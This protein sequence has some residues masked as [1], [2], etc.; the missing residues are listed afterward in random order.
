MK[1]SMLLSRCLV[2]TFLLTLSIST[3]SF[4]Q[5]STDSTASQPWK[6]IPIPPLPAFHPEQPKRIVLKNGL[7]IFLEEDHELPFIDGFIEM[8]GGGRDLPASKAGMIDLYGQTWRTSGTTTHSGDDLDDLLEAKAAKVETGGDVDSTSVSWSSLSSDFDQVF[9]ITVDLLEHPKFDNQKLELAKQQEATG[10]VRRN[11]DA[12][13]IAEREAFKLIYGADSP[14]GRVPELASVMSVTTADLDAFHKKTAIPNGMII[15][16]TGDFDSAVME[17]KLRAAFEG[18]PKG[19]PIVTPK[20]DFPG[21]KPGVYSID[22]TDVNQSNIWVVG[23]GTKRDNPDYYALS[24]M[25]EVFSGGFGSRLMQ[26][27]RTKMGLAYSVSG[28]YASSYDHPGIFYTAASTKSATTAKTTKALLDQIAALKSEP[29]TDVEVRKAKDQLLNSFVF[30]YD[31][32]DKLLNEQ[33]R[34]EFYGYP[35]D[36]LDRYHDAIEKVTPAD[37]ERVAKKYIDPSKLAVLVV[38]NTATYGT[39]LSEV[40]PKLGKVQTLD[41]SIPGAPTGGPQG[42]GMGPGVGSGAAERQ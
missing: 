42:P 11:D 23:L 10:I 36:F 30:R 25:N 38:G 9:G 1:T 35:L 6:S 32:K 29:F 5:I 39:P 41:I 20:E 19:T 24:V 28:A 15:G 26:I 18:L 21:P 22:K 2:S 4:A 37:L 40:D 16:V 7:V 8:H 17:K 33:A 3:M 12:S 34:L 27:V 14:Y 13:G 31:T